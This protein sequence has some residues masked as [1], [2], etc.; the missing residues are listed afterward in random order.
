MKFLLMG[1][2]KLLKFA[3][4]SKIFLTAGTMLLSVV[5]Y[6][7]VFG[8]P[9]ATGFVGLI[10]IHEMGHFIAAKKR[11]LNVGAPT[12]IPF[13]GAWIQLK[14]Q[15]KSAEVEA[16][17]AMAGPMLGTMAAF[18]LYLFAQDHHPL[19]MALA[20]AGFILNLFNLIPLSPLDG[21]RV[22]S[23]V[24]PKIGILGLI[25]L[26]MTFM[27]HPNPIVIVIAIMAVP[28]VISVWRGTYIYPAGYHETPNFV[29]AQYFFQYLL[30]TVFLATMV[31]VLHK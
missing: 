4:L 14:E 23:I 19:L 31:D 26:G 16:Y 12:F 3:K 30:L 13:V 24:S 29:K 18:V 10:F 25:I 9:Y 8:W 17:V 21:G 20:H 2:F 27:W 1:I 6:S 15:P 11:G 5:T 22:I 7:F 28:Q